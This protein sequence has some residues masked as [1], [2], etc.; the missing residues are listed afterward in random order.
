MGDA[1]GTV[2]RRRGRQF[3]DAMPTCASWTAS[4]CRDLRRASERHVMESGS[5]PDKLYFYLQGVSDARRPASPRQE[6]PPGPGGFGVEDAATAAAPAPRCRRTSQTLLAERET[7]R[8]IA[9]DQA[10]VAQARSTIRRASIPQI[11]YDQLM[12]GYSGESK[13]DVRL[14]MTRRRH[15]EGP[16]PQKRAP[17]VRADS[18]FLHAEGLQRGHRRRHA[19]AGQAVRRGGMG[20]GHRRRSARFQ[21]AEADG[22]GHRAVRAQLQQHLGCAP[23]RPRDRAV[24]DRR[25]IWRS[26]GDPRRLGLAADAPR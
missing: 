7:L 11:M 26:L 2:S 22:A 21:L 14:D 24:L 9:L 17:A 20:M 18:G 10:L 4:S 13:D 5:E 15:R 12:R 3:R 25:A 16:P 23:Q 1:L 6:T 8:P 19:P